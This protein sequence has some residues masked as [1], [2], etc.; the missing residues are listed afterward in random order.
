MYLLY[1]LFLPDVR[2]FTFEQTSVWRHLMTKGKNFKRTITNNTVTSWPS[3]SVDIVKE[4]DSVTL[5]LY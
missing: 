3:R 2:T 4:N 5:R 1:K